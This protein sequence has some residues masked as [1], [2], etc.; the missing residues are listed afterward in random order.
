MRYREVLNAPWWTYAVF[1]G[2]TALLAFTFAAVVGVP[3]A[4]VLFVVVV[5]IGSA[6]NWR[7][8]TQ[9]IVDEEYL[10]V[11]SQRLPLADV[12]EVTALDEGA[13]NTMA[14]RDADPRAHLVLHTLSSKSGV[15]I[16]LPGS[17]TPYWLVTSDRPDALAEVLSRG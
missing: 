3:T 17:Q 9:I 13:M 12:G 7:R 8:R 2:L 6:L 1:A 10:R 4:A 11:G 5:V 14:G 16:E 15:K